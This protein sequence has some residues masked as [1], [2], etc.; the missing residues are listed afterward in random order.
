MMACGPE[1]PGSILHLAKVHYDVIFFLGVFMIQFNLS[2]TIFRQ[3]LINL[4]PLPGFE[5]GTTPVAPFS[6]DDLKAGQIL[7]FSFFGAHIFFSHF[8]SK[9]LLL[10]LYCSYC[11]PHCT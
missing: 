3:K 1:D 8:T 2:Y 10:K 7:P 9:V 6:Y 4:S 11:A 5:P